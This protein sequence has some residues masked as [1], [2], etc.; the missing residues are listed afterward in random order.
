MPFVNDG[1]LKYYVYDILAAE[2]VRH[3]VFT[4]HGGVSAAPW[5][6]LNTGLTVGD[7]ESDVHENRRRIFT[8]LGSDT[9]SV[10]DV[11][12]VHSDRILHAGAPRRE[13]Q[14]QQADGMVSRTSGITLMMRFAD[15]VPLL[16]YDPGKKVVAMAHAGW[17]G[18]AL[19]IAAR[20][21]E[22]M[23][24]TF[25]CIPADVIACIG[26]S[27]CIEHYQVGHEMPGR[28]HRFTEDQ[29]QK[30][31]LQRG[32]NLHLDLWQANEIVLQDAGVGQ[33]ENCR[34]C[35]ACTVEDWFSH[36]AEHGITGRFAAVIGL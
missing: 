1:S 17:K 35:T 15:C 9:E 27:I 18:T 21:V 12:H 31:F 30:L 29:I 25:G 19:R 32:D 34:I 33:I 16:L 3:G 20:V 6:T 10:F 22:A 5:D 23:V 7:R 36:R 24:D 2:G 11:C 14:I 26:P 28:F 4:R 13:A 8:A